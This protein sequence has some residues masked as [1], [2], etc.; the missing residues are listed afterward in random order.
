MT[1]TDYLELMLS[2]LPNGQ[3]W[4]DLRQ[5][6][7]GVYEL[8]SALAEEFGRVDARA[9][10]LRSEMDPRY[11]TELLREWED[12]AGLPDPCTNAKAVTLQERRAAVVS[13]LTYR[14]GQTKAF[15][16]GLATALGYSITIIEYAPWVCGLSRL[17]T[18][19]LCGGHNV[20]QHWRVRVHG[21]RVG[22]FRTGTSQCGIDLLTKIS[23]AYDL[24]CRF[25]RNN[26]GHRNLHFTYEGTRP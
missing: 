1:A 12:F 26:Q 24:E 13:K 23:R 4:D 17:G 5:P 6:G 20:R 8:L 22:R 9:R 25:K 2:L 10:Q 19:T 14:A 21:P 7:S 11:A 16:V 18:D 15:Y 3:L